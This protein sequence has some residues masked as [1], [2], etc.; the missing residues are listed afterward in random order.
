MKKPSPLSASPVAL[1]SKALAGVVLGT[2]LALAL[3]GWFAYL[4][5][6]GAA[7]A[8][9]DQFT[10]WIVPPMALGIVCASFLFRTGARA[11][12]WLA[13]ANL[14]AWPVLSYLR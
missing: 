9:K 2:A 11:W 12:L 7:A 14:L 1:C 8:N 10:M 4:S 6:G 13:A 5:P 3:S